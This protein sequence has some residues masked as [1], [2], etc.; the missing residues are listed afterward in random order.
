MRL[1]PS[2][3]RCPLIKHP[4]SG[5]SSP[6]RGYAR[7]AAA[8]LFNTCRL[9]QSDSMRQKRRRPSDEDGHDSD[10]QSL[11]SNL[12]AILCELHTPVQG[13]EEGQDDSAV[14][15]LNGFDGVKSRHGGFEVEAGDV[16]DVCE[17]QLEYSSRS[18]RRKET[19]RMRPTMLL[20][21]EQR[22]LYLCRGREV[23]RRDQSTGRVAGYQRR[24]ISWC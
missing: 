12:S 16:G 9:T 20:A 23:F 3:N 6:L 5:K 13:T 8:A 19:Y 15:D 2:S 4:H 24:R 7:S 10:R 21:R 1:T 17:G 14:R 22:S 11:V 18:R